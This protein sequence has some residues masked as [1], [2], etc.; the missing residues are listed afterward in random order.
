[1]FSVSG[2]L[3]IHHSATPVHT[4]AQLTLQSLDASNRDMRHNG[5]RMPRRGRRPA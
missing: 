1:M 4:L 2:V 3:C 5:T